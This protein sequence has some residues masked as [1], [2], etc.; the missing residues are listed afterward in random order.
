MTVV[1]VAGPLEA[2]TTTS[3]VIVPPFLSEVAK[4][5]FRS[6]AAAACRVGISVASTSSSSS[7]SSAEEEV[8]LN[9]GRHILCTKSSQK[10][11]C[12]KGVWRRPNYS[13]R[14]SDAEGR[15]ALA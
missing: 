3:A 1:S 7:S 10:T 5:D 4:R 9:L 15:A 6:A 12:E 8:L 13:H 11:S 14:V 2:T